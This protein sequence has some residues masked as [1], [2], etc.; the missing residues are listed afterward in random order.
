VIEISPIS[1]WCFRP[2]EILQLD[3]PL[4][5]EAEVGFNGID[6]FDPWH[7]WIVVDL[8]PG[9]LFGAE[10]WKEGSEKPPDFFLLLGYGQNPVSP[11][12]LVTAGVLA[13]N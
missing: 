13:K 1:I 6:S 11:A 2:Y 7:V 10:G 3:Q 12:S 5:E 8:L 9:P 4:A